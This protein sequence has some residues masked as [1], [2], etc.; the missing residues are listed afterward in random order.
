MGE[1]PVAGG[2]GRAQWAVRTWGAV[3]PAWAVPL[4]R[5]AKILAT[6]A[7]LI[8]TGYFSRNRLGPRLDF[9]YFVIS[10]SASNAGLISSH[11]RGVL[12]SLK[13][14]AKIPPL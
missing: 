9:L 6:L 11:F 10:S 12:K 13:T 7:I 8:G 3:P 1:T 14:P 2:E 5:P 4:A